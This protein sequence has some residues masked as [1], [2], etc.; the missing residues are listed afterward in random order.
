MVVI[1]GNVFDTTTGRALRWPLERV[2][3]RAR[4]IDDVARAKA[5]VGN[6]EVGGFKLR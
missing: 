2:R 3:E 6:T 5:F 1:V 4:E